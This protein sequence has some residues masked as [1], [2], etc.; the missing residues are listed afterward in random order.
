MRIEVSNER[1]SSEFMQRCYLLLRQPRF[2]DTVEDVKMVSDLKK[3]VAKS[4]DVF[5]YSVKVWTHAM[6]ES[7]HCKVDTL[8]WQNGLVVI[9]LKEGIHPDFPGLRIWRVLSDRP[10]GAI[11][12][13][14]DRKG[15]TLKMLMAGVFDSQ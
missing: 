5:P 2:M 12:V 9:P 7:I 14:F 3:L 15:E 10:G 1:M 11:Q 8:E 6:N 4:F 13:A